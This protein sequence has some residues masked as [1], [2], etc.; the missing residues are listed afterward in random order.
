MILSRPAEKGRTGRGRNSHQLVWV[1]YAVMQGRAER[2]EGTKEDGRV[3]R[4]AGK[5]ERV[6]GRPVWKEINRG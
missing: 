3:E 2:D 4:R 5:E 1:D 6:I